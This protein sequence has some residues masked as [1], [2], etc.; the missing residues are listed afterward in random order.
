MGRGRVGCLGF[1]KLRRLD[2]HYFEGWDCRGYAVVYYYIMVIGFGVAVAVAVSGIGI[3]I[4]IGIG[5]IIIICIVYRSH[6]D[7]DDFVLMLW[8]KGCDQHFLHS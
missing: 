4:G 1:G 5:R 2:T 7:D 6:V 3:G 8:Q